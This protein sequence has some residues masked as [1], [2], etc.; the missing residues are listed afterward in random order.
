MSHH[1][2]LKTL[3]TEL[4]EA[5][6]SYLK[7]GGSDNSTVLT[8]RSELV[9]L[10]IATFVGYRDINP[11]VVGCHNSEEAVM[12]DNRNAVIK[13]V[14]EAGEAMYLPSQKVLRDADKIYASR[15][16]NFVCPI[17]SFEQPS[18]KAFIEHE[19]DGAA[20]F[21]YGWLERGIPV[22]NNYIKEYNEVA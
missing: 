10:A 20:D 1:Y 9:A 6:G 15:W 2:Q 12:A 17:V 4:N 13:L 18:V 11:M 5:A 22:V 8:K 21:I 16:E 3:V 7:N 19:C 14:S